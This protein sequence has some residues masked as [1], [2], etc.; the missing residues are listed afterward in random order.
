MG[1]KD[2][3]K[4]LNSNFINTSFDLEQFWNLENYGTLPKT[5]PNLLTKDKK[6]AVNI[7]ENTCD[8]I[9]GKYQV[10]LL[11]KK[12]DLVLPCNRNL[13]LKRLENLEKKFSKNQ[14]FAKRYS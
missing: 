4:Y 7:L 9:K 3:G 8:F 12:D 2:Q 11:L 10:G 5:H 13:A 14:L 6:R 1:G